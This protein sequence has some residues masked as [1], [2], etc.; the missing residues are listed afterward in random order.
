MSRST[1]VIEQRE[2][3][4]GDE[5]VDAAPSAVIRSS[6][7]LPLSLTDASPVVSNSTPI[8]P[9]R[10]QKVRRADGSY[11]RSV[12]SQD[13]LPRLVSAT[14][15]HNSAF[16][17]HHAAQAELPPA[18]DATDM[19]ADLGA[20]RRISL[21]ES[22]NSFLDLDNS[23]ERRRTLLLPKTRDVD[24]LSFLE[25]FSPPP[26]PSNEPTTPVRASTSGLP[27]LPV[28]DWSA[29]L[30]PK[31][32]G[33]TT[34]SL[35]RERDST[36]TLHASDSAS[37]HQ[38]L[39]ALS[40]N[41]DSLHPYGNSRNSAPSAVASN[42]SVGSQGSLQA[43]DHFPIPPDAEL[44]QL[45]QS[46]ARPAPTLSRTSTYN[47]N[48]VGSVYS[49]YASR[50]RGDTSEY[51]TAAESVNGAPTPGQRDRDSWL[52]FESPERSSIRL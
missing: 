25:D 32:D 11:P 29:Q 46:G 19:P 2:S 8:S 5:A 10:P 28:F 31:D 30:Q 52:D 34:K 27:G 23:P 47:Y 39:S 37:Q 12:A 33:Q 16:D 1:P 41:R 7:E 22:T 21:A 51:E 17:N 40:N 38:R 36:Y 9:E 42:L 24:S 49:Y 20:G 45:S 18:D 43:L 26:T 3:F 6:S 4:F 13:G 50:S 48:D 35:Y 15:N 14:S 44:P